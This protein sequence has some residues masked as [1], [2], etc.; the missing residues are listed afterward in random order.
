M[1]VEDDIIRFLG[2]S[3]PIAQRMP[4]YVPRRAQ[5]D[6]ALE[7]ARTLVTH[8]GRAV[9][10]AGTGTGKSL[11]YLTAALFSD[12]QVVI[13]TGTKALQ[14]Q[15]IEKDIPLVLQALLDMT[16]VEKTA[17][18]MKGRN[19]YLCLARYQRFLA[20]PRFAFADEA[21][22]WP[23]LRTWADVTTSGD[24]AE[25]STLPDGWVTWHDLD[26]SSETCI[27]QKCA[28][29]S[30]CFVTRM[31]RAAEAADLIVV[32]HHLLCA[33]QRVR[34]E[35]MPA[36]GE[37]VLEGEDERGGFAQVIPAAD[38]II[39]DEAHSLPDVATDYFGVSLA[40][41][42]VE[43]LLRD[44]KKA[45]DGLPTAKRL[46]LL[47]GGQRVQAAFEHVFEALEGSLASGDRVR[48][49]RELE[50]RL[51]PAR[52]LALETTDELSTQLEAL[53]QAPEDGKLSTVAQGE[54][55]GLSRRASQIAEE[56][57]FVLGPAL[58]DP[59]F[60]AFVEGKKR[61]LALGAAPI[62]V[63]D[64]LA[65]TLLGT[66]R[67]VV[68]TSATLAVGHRTDAF[69]EKVGLP[70]RSRALRAPA[71]EAAEDAAAEETAMAAPS[72]SAV[73]SVVYP[74]PF[75]HARRAALY[76]PA[77]MPEPD[78][79]GFWPRFDE[80]L[81]FLWRLTGGGALVLFTSHRAMESTYERM[82]KLAEDEGFLLIKQGDS[83][84]AKLLDTLRA[85]DGARGA[86]L[87][88]TQSFW[89]GVD[90]QGRALRL[91]VIDRLPFRMPTDP[92]QVA[93]QELV[94][95]R[96]GN[97]FFDLSLPEAAISLKQGVGRL[98]RSHTDAGIV[99]LLDG[100]LRSRSYGK[101]LLGALPPMTRV[102]S[103]KA[104]SSFWERFVQPAL[105]AGDDEPASRSAPSHENSPPDAPKTD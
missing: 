41:P 105:F 45:A 65:K 75:D 26:A 63:A 84:K 71:D 74:S 4:G 83:P 37:A 96:G 54:L 14:D 52:D 97:P 90:V 12:Q 36:P 16:G 49:R 15:L 20:E 6:M 53:A 11:A 25:L 101:T 33:D 57:A 77:G 98:L 32:N 68:M 39:I 93:R 3:G 89:E 102:G 55:E 80:E 50:A 72:S 28:Q 42:R 9:I 21:T 18:L 59:R 103:Q 56:L 61:G 60:V 51:A 88:A 76:A 86:L 67:A 87:F 40:T 10:E 91:V 78:H 104:L 66:A 31:R 24:R 46:A 82:K 99:A 30:E 73:R 69:E 58:S 5:I 17:A 62:D 13:A 34:L 48:L 43:R 81:R 47:G 64:A 27:G 44:L 85:H 70:A 2:A 22:A 92:V 1:N 100:R 29:F 38:A 79:P 94:R 95:A 7:V 23:A 19:N 8:R 35:G